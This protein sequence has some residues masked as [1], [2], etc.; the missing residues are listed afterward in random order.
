MPYGKRH[1]SRTEN[2]LWLQS[3][4]QESLHSRQSFCTTARTIRHILQANSYA[5]GSVDKGDFR[6][7]TNSCILTEKVPFRSQFFRSSN[8]IPASRRENGLFQRAARIGLLDTK[9]FLKPT[10]SLTTPEITRSHPKTAP[11]LGWLLL[12]LLLLQLTAG[13]RVTSCF[14]PASS[15]YRHSMAAVRVTSIDDLFATPLLP[16]CSLWRL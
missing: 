4:L 7:K 1:N 11:M 15:A 6:S 9:K 3:V 12:L 5:V 2:P 16:L 10:A 13:Q 14:P 8:P